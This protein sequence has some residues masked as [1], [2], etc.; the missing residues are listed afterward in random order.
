MSIN[1]SRPI[2]R[3][4]SCGG[5]DDQGFLSQKLFGIHYNTEVLAEPLAEFKVT[6]V[7][8]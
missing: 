7:G 2:D 8:P 4:Q 5:S 3:L 1:L 6:H